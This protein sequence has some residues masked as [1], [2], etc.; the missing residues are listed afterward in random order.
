MRRVSF[1]DISLFPKEEVKKDNTAPLV[2]PVVSPSPPSPTEPRP[3]SGPQGAQKSSNPVRL[4][5]R[6]F[7]DYENKREKAQQAMKARV[8]PSEPRYPTTAWSGN[9]FSESMPAGPPR[10]NSVQGAM[11]GQKSALKASIGPL[12]PSTTPQGLSSINQVS[13]GTRYGW[14]VLGRN[15]WV[16]LGRNW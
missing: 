7:V 15:R 12:S 16:G 2:S 3:L 11:G 8:E 5:P 9:Y 13:E 1:K 10:E 4:T 14:V 6:L